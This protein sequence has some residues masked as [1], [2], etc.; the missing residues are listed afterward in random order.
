MIEFFVSSGI[1]SYQ[2]PGGSYKVRKRAVPTV[3]IYP[4]NGGAAGNVLA[5]AQNGVRAASIE[6][7]ADT[8]F[9]IFLT[10]MTQADLVRYNWVAN[11]RL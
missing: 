11:A 8:G 10:G 7:A 1:G 4:V 9:N 5:I 3:T 2:M 6:G